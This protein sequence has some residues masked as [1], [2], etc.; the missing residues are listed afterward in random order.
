MRNIL[1][2][3]KLS[4]S[5][6]DP[7]P[8]RPLKNIFKSRACLR[9]RFPAAISL[10]MG[11]ACGSKMKLISHLS[12]SDRCEIFSH[13]TKYQFRRRF[14]ARCVLGHGGGVGRDRQ[15]VEKR[16]PQFCF[17]LE[18]GG[19]EGGPRMVPKRS[20]SR[21]RRGRR[22]AE[23]FPRGPRKFLENPT[24]PSSNLTDRGCARFH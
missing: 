17:F 5:K 10:R 1:L 21:R 7:R 22:S 2:F 9:D 19:G 16:F 14:L 24:W 6:A 11:G 13:F 20:A 15:E 18:E 4:I 23:W 8:L 12:D 3:Y